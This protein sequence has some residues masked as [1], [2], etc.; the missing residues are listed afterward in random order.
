MLSANCSWAMS[1]QS[2][3]L[4]VAG[5]GGELN[6]VAM[7]SILGPIAQLLVVL[8]GPE[9]GRSHQEALPTAGSRRRCG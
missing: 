7:N 4:F 5:L 1:G 3:V 2:V 8:G 9:R 6:N